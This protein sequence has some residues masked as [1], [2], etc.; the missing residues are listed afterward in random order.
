MGPT[1]PRDGPLAFRL[2]QAVCGWAQFT[3]GNFARC[4]YD[5]PP[6]PEARRRNST[7]A[8]VSAVG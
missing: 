8:S 1:P 5:T 2:G 7:P 4:C 3:V 6:G